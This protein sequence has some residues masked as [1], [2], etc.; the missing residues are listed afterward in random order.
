[1]KRAECSLGGKRV[2]VDRH[3]GG[4]WG[5]VA[6][7]W[8]IEPLLRGISSSSLWPVIL[9]C[10][11]LSPYLVYLRVLPPVRASLSQD[12]FWCRGL[13]VGWRHL[14]WGG[15]PSLL[16]SE[17]PFCAR[18]VGRVSLS[19]RMRNMQCLVW[20]GL[21]LSSLLL[22]SSPWGICPQGTASSCSAWGP[23]I[24]CLSFCH[25]APVRLFFFF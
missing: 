25:P 19:W 21:S 15:A 8:W 6:C 20:A 13:W 2:R 17:E 9:L 24:S 5:S 3:T 1:M 10:L 18:A 4:L 23:S 16:T 22:L 7:S 11:V 14:L 12:G